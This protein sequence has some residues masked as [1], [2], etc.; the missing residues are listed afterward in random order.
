[1]WSSNL[2]GVFMNYEKYIRLAAATMLFPMS[3]TFAQVWSDDPLL[4]PIASE[5]T[6][7]IDK[8]ADERLAGR[9]RHALARRKE[10]EPA[11]IAIRANSGVVTLMG[12][13][14]EATQVGLVEKTALSVLGVKEVRNALTIRPIGQ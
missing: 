8:V 1:M 6:K 11:T 3:S 5:A 13:E 14:P 2:T 7:S 10:I 9:V 4:P 12:S